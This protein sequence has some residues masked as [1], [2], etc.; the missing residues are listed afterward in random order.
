MVSDEERLK[1]AA[2]ALAMHKLLESMR[3]K[4]AYKRAA[5]ACIRAYMAGAPEAQVNSEGE[6]WRRGPAPEKGRYFL[7]RK[8]KE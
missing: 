4:A 8:M 3:G 2:D 1:A 6:I 7:L 5:R